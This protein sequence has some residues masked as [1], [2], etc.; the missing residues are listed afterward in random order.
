[1]PKHMPMLTWT[2]EGVPRWIGTREEPIGRLQLGNG[3]WNLQHDV[4]GPRGTYGLMN[5]YIDS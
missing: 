1:M 5:G 4:S 3:T 2:N